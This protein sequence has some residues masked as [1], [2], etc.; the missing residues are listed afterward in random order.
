MTYRPP[1]CAPAKP[2]RKA[3]AAAFDAQRPLDQA[4]TGAV[5][6]KPI[7]RNWNESVRDIGEKKE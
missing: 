3:V 2:T 1:R 7:P 5:R 4:S 6:K